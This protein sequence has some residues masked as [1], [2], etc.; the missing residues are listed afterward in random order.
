MAQEPTLPLKIHIPDGS[1]V[2]DVTVK[3]G[4]HILPAHRVEIVLDAN[5]SRLEEQIK[6]RV[7]AY[8]D[9]FLGE[10]VS[11]VVKQKIGEKEYLLV[12]P[13]EYDTVLKKR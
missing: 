4:E 9:S 1:S 2:Y 3:L 11:S 7:D 10:N 8:F 12:D 6:A 13:D 5:A